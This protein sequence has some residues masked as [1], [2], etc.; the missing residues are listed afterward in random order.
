M[1][2]LKTRWGTYILS[3]AVRI[4]I[5]SAKALKT[6]EVFIAVDSYKHLL[7]A[8]ETERDAFV[9]CSYMRDAL[10][11]MFQHPHDHA[12]HWDIDDEIKTAL[13][14]LEQQGIVE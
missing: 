10:H 14:E 13:F 2:R 9:F 1:L 4:D 12:S 5:Y 3:N 7:M 8:F 6:W 11:E